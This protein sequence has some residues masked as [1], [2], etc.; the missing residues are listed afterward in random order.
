MEIRT[1]GIVGAGRWA[2]A[3]PMFL[4]WRAMTF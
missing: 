3:S 1:V 2:M 4:R